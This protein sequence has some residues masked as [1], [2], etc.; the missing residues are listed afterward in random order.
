MQTVNYMYAPEVPNYRP[1]RVVCVRVL[2]YRG[3]LAFSQSIKNFKRFN[4]ANGFLKRVLWSGVKRVWRCAA[5]P[6]KHVR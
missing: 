5:I 1:T 3:M 6:E 2:T 4:G